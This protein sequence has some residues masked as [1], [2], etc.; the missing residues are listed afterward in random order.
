MH[1]IGSVLLGL[2][3]GNRQQFVCELT[4]GSRSADLLRNAYSEEGRAVTTETNGID[5]SSMRRGLRVDLRGLSIRA[6]LRQPAGERTRVGRQTIS[7]HP[8]GSGQ[9]ERRAST[10]SSSALSCRRVNGCVLFTRWNISS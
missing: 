1:I 5:L 9:M 8:M 7:W 10:C 6:S 4:L 2:V 3:R